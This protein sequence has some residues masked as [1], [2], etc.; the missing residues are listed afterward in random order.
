MGKKKRALL[1]YKRLGKLSKKLEKK[2]SNL[3]RAN[4]ELFGF[5]AKE[6]IEETIAEEQVEQPVQVEEP[7]IEE[8]PKTTRKTTKRPATTKKKTTTTTKKPATTKKTTTTTR[9]RRTTKTKSDA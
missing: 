8:K 1:R 9:R 2:F 4:F 6:T 7:K 5:K 3:L